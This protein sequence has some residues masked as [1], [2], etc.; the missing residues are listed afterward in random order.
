MPK[1]K[2]FTIDLTTQDLLELMSPDLALD[3][4]TEIEDIGA[5][6]LEELHVPVEVANLDRVPA[7]TATLDDSI[8]IELSAQEMDSLLDGVLRND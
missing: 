8:E 4:L 2:E 5:L 3:G 6:D 7:P 1:L